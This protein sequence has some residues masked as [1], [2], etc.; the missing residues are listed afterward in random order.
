VVTGATFGAAGYCR[1][2]ASPGVR[3]PGT[4]IAWQGQN[5][6]PAPNGTPGTVF[7]HFDER[8][9]RRRAFHLVAVPLDKV[10]NL[11]VA[12][13]LPDHSAPSDGSLVAAEWTLISEIRTRALALKRQG[14]WN[15]RLSNATVQNHYTK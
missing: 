5:W 7:Q 4:N 1:L 15:D 8:Q 2:I 11:N 9:I 13:V 6:L 14:M 3:A 10:A 12:H